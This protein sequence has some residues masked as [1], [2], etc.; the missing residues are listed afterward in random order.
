MNCEKFKLIEKCLTNDIVVLKNVK[1]Y[2]KGLLNKVLKK[3]ILLQINSRTGNRN[4]FKTLKN[5]T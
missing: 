5:Q 1:K 3:L 4:N 2:L